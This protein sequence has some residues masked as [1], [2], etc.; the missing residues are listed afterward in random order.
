MKATSKSKQANG[1]FY[2]NSYGRLRISVFENVSEKDG[3]I[4]FSTHIQRN[5][6]DANGQWKTGGLSEEDLDNMP[7]AVEIAK[8][9]IKE[10]QASYSKQ[11]LA[12]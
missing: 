3:K 8:E 9:Q 4:R 1:P 7:K 5:Y 12:A 11:Q 2:A 10:R 6:K